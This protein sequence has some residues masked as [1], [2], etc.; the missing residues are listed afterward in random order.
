MA[1]T[2]RGK[3]QDC[4]VTFTGPTGTVDILNI[5]G[6]RSWNGTFKYK[7]LE[8]GYQ[9]EFTQRYDEIFMG[10]DGDMEAHIAGGDFLVF[11]QQVKDRAQR[12][13]IAE[14]EFSMLVSVTF[15]TGQRARILFPD[16]H[17]GDMP[18]KSPAR[19]EYVTV[20]IDFSGSEGIFIP[21]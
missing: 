21:T 14:A 7:K 15:G 8:E 6:I 10:C 13:I 9:G 5:S 1:A 19:D 20:G 16:V 18:F 11:A 4:R 2:V 12:N 17:F 3:G